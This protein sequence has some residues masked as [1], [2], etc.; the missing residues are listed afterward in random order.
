[1]KRILYSLLLIFCVSS[2][3]FSADI[4]FSGKVIDAQT[5]EPLPG[6]TITIQDLKI[7]AITDLNGVFSFK[8]IPDQGKF[9]IQIS[10]LGYKYLN[11][12]IDFS[13]TKSIVFE[14][15]E[16]TISNLPSRR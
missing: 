1:M 12:T 6:A 8:R 2:L 9:L 16:R 10:Y 13:T 7:S 5:K 15:V 11:K 14:I 4:T 3:A